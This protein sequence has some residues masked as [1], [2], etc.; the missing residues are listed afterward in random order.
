[1]KYINTISDLLDALTN[2]NKFEINECC[3]NLIE[4]S[5]RQLMSDYEKE[6]I[7][8]LSDSISDYLV[9]NE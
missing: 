2:H 1:M 6:I 8:E 4:L 9:T 7:S 5:S 3:E